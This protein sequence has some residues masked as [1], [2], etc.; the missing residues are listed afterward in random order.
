MFVFFFFLL[1][2]ICNIFGAKNSKAHQNQHA[3][4]VNDQT[5]VLASDCY[6]SQL[7]DFL[8]KNS[9]AS[10]NDPKE[11]S[12]KHQHQQKHYSIYSLNSLEPNSQQN[13]FKHKCKRAV[14]NFMKGLLNERKLKKRKQNLNQEEPIYLEV[15]YMN[16]AI[17]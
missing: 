2:Q 6:I 12:G 11:I 8:S 3:Q 16:S 14:Y 5:D 9:N 17:F 4:Q 1:L 15:R 7:K 13:N 10:L